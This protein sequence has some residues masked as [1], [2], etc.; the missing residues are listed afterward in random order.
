MDVSIVVVNDLKSLLLELTQGKLNKALH[1]SS[2][3]NILSTLCTLTYTCIWVCSTVS[4]NVIH[5][6]G[7]AKRKGMQKQWI[8]I[9]QVMNI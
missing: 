7:K 9:R 6:L 1:P 4:E 8:C 2:L 5:V 3:A